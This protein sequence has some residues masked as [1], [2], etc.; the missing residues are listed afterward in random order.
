MHALLAGCTSRGCIGT[1][2]CWT[3]AQQATAVQILP[4]QPVI[5]VIS[6]AEQTQ[7]ILPTIACKEQTRVCFHE[8]ATQ[9][10]YLNT[11]RSQ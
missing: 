1:R 6:R 2:V 9:N 4:R 7:V 10:T 3:G 11:C 8:A 5:T